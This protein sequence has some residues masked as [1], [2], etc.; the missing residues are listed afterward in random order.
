MISIISYYYYSWTVE[1]QGL[2]GAGQNPE[3]EMVCEV[4]IFPELS[5]QALSLAASHFMLVHSHL[6]LCSSVCVRSTKNLDDGTTG[7]GL[8][9]GKSFL[10]PTAEQPVCFSS[11]LRK[12]MAELPSCLP[13]LYVGEPHEFF[14]RVQ[15]RCKNY[16]SVSENSCFLSHTFRRVFPLC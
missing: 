7:H 16:Q 11:V 14:L 15:K 5:R 8:R 12:T 6:G 2:G 4:C 13:E 3:K 10:R 1:C 9:E